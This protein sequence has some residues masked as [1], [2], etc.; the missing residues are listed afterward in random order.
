MVKRTLKNLIKT[1]NFLRYRFNYLLNYIII[2][3]FSILL[4]ILVIYSLFFLEIPFLIK[5]LLGFLSSVLFSFVLNAKLNFKVPK[6]KNTRTFILFLIISTFTF[7]LNLILIILLRDIISLRY[8]ILRLTTASIV[9]MLSYTL[10]RKITFDFIKKVGIAIYLT[11]NEDIKKIYS[12]IRYYADF[13][14]IDL[15]DKTFSKK[16]EEINLSLIKEIDKTWGLKK[17]LHIMSKKPSF[18]IKKL[19]KNVDSIIFHL[20][21]D[22]SIEDI[23]KLCEKY[24]KKKGLVL[25][26]DLEIKDIIK[27]LPQIEFV[28]IMGINELG[29]SGQ[30]LNVDSLRKVNELNKLKKKY[31]FDI[32]FDGGVKPTNINKINAKYVVSASGL[33]SSKN[34]IKSFMELK[35]SLRYS[36]HKKL[37]R[38]DIFLGIR[39]AVES[40]EFI[41]S[42]SIVGSFSEGKGLKGINDIDIVVILDKLTKN[43]FEIV[44]ETFERLRRDIESRHGY[45][46][47]INNTLGPLK[48][49]EK[50]IVFHLMIYDK[51]SHKNHCIK[52]PFTCFDWQRSKL[53]IKKPLS[54]IYKVSDL[55]LKHFFGSRRSAEE[56]LSEIKSN[57]LS[58]RTY[59][60]KG[61]NVVEKKA[62]KEMDN[63]D[64]IEFSYHIIKFLMSNFLKI[65]YFEN[66]VYD[67]E[68]MLK[69]YFIIFPLHKKLHKR[70]IKTLFK[71]KNKREFIELLWLTR[72][73]ENFIKDFEL[74][75]KQLFEIK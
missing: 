56:Y 19:N 42:G 62:Y 24:N 71:L 35:T 26:L 43:K 59:K 60:I 25:T 31:H 2:G 17:M 1:I 7:T 70:R 50:C 45:P 8:D 41:E 68:E 20:N 13:I 36:L 52:S 40:L 34:P 39:K 27:Y 65:Y 38:R 57:R 10:H 74:Q 67:F 12:K 73:L 51:E 32:I 63:R 28:Q 72:A 4:E 23:I 48:F 15:V 66:K 37:L 53:F 5:I 75:F 49:N 21:I 69:R 6:S 11:K 33:L 29:K 58:Y 3:F 14:H 64:K 30:V 44:L 46:V 47:L 55:Q 9:F 16:A 18:W 22:E 54:E 61:N